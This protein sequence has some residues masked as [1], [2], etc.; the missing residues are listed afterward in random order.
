METKLTLN[1]PRDFLVACAINHIRPQQLLQ[2][3]INDISLPAYMIRQDMCEAD[4][5]MNY[6]I[7]GA[8]GKYTDD[9]IQAFIYK[10]YNWTLYQLEQEIAGIQQTQQLK[11]VFQ[12]FYDQWYDALRNSDQFEILPSEVRNTHQLKPIRHIEV[13][14]SIRV[15]LEQSDT[16][17]LSICED[18]EI[19]SCVSWRVDNDRLKLVYTGIDQLETFTLVENQTVIFQGDSLKPVP[20]TTI[21]ISC[22]NLSSITLLNHAEM[23]SMGNLTSDVLHVSTYG[24][25]RL[26]ASLQ[27]NYLDCTLKD[28]STMMLYGRADNEHVLVSSKGRYYTEMSTAKTHIRMNGDG[29]ASITPSEE[30][31]AFLDDNA[32]LLYSEHLPVENIN[33]SGKSAAHRDR[34]F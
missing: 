32:V 1:F 9:K 25:S 19:K 21:T 30:L 13:S 33:C 4:L 29:R 28:E 23:W 3:F 16:E 31:T 20:A 6:L 34:Y 2:S 26:L 27:V 18:P 24:D 7:I 5:A 8:N 11:P 14:G 12:A 10:K 22:K 15:I 17:A